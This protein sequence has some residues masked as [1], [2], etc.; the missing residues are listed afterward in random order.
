MNKE[1]NLAVIVI[2][3]ALLIIPIGYIGFSLFYNGTNSDGHWSLEPTQG[4][5]YDGNPHELVVFESTEDTVQY[6]TDGVHYTSAVPTGIDA[7]EYT[8][9]FKVMEGEQV[10]KEDKVKATIAPMPV[11]VKAN[12]CSKVNGEPDPVFTAEVSVK[13]V[14]FNYT[15]SREPGEDFGSYAIT[16]TGTEVQG[17]YRAVYEKGFLF[18]YNEIVVVTPN[19]ASKAFGADD[20]VFTATVSGA[21]GISYTLSREEGEKTGAYKIYATGERVQGDYLV[22]FGTGIFTIMPT[23]SEWKS[24]PTAN[25]YTFD[26]YKKQLV[27]PGT[28]SGGQVLYRLSTGY[29]SAEIPTASEPGTYTIYCKVAGDE[30]HADSK[31]IVLTA[32]IKEYI[33]NGTEKKQPQKLNG[34]YMIYLPSE[35]AWVSAQNKS[36]NGFSGVTFQ[37]M[38]DMDLRHKSWTP[39]GSVDSSTTCPFKGIMNGNGYTISNLFVDSEEYSG[40]FGYVSGGML[41]GIN[42]A[43]IEVHGTEYVGGIAGYLDSQADGLG[44][45]HVDVTGNRYVGV[46]AG[47]QNAG[48]YDCVISYATLTCSRINMSTP[49]ILTYLGNDAGGISGMCNADIKDC[50]VRHLTIN[51]YRNV[52]G[53]VGNV[54]DNKRSIVISGCDVSFSTIMVNVNE[55]S[56]DI[57]VGMISDTTVLSYNTF[58]NAGVVFV[59]SEDGDDTD[60]ARNLFTGEYEYIISKTDGSVEYKRIGESAVTEQNMHQIVLD[61][62]TI[63]RQSE[64][65]DHPAI[66]VQTGAYIVLIIKNSVTLTGGIDSDAIR[67]YAGG[68]VTVTGGGSLTVVGNN[69]HEYY[70]KDG[71]KSKGD[72]DTYNGTG[73]CGIGYSKGATGT[74]RIADLGSISAYGWGN[75]GYGIGGDGATVIINKSTV[76]IARGGFDETEFLVSSYGNEE[77]EGGPAIGGAT[78]I[79]NNGTHIVEAY[80]G[81]KSAGIGTRFWQGGI[82]EISDSTI[83]KVVGGNGSAGIGSSHPNRTADNPTSVTIVI[84]NSEITAIGGYYG[85]GIGSGYDRKTGNAGWIDLTIYITSFSKITAEG[86]KFAADIGTG[87]HSGIL[88]GAI[89]SNVKYN[90]T[91]GTDPKDNSDHTYSYVAQAIGYGVVD[92]SRE[93]ASLM[94]G[95]TPVITSFTIAGEPLTNPF[96][97][98]RLAE[99]KEKYPTS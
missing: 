5:V 54:Q 43:F 90:V 96:D 74:I 91:E 13:G 80:G 88:K 68:E 81:S 53:L 50:A 1:R 52:G 92:Y 4:L 47:Y 70:D 19:D 98:D 84:E 10:L 40:L 30:S 8:I 60:A 15:L 55:K 63:G 25:S 36:N 28:G 73:G 17:N 61:G 72:K 23:A 67:V 39:I 62:V 3:V 57:F 22:E 87:Y 45:Y 9:Y 35:L 56:G 86:G 83:D 64:P 46:I 94:S 77:A 65:T 27:N 12:D 33:W 42:V 44:A 93:A 78:I 37:I 41:S 66:T 11:I 18:I 32:E 29:Y 51:A 59:T 16:P 31:E 49:Y 76:T 71:Y 85:A 97:P 69:G 24:E 82:I 2:I 7:Q 38:H 99:V 89:E 6:S 75:H 95:T 58:A 48:I 21:T 26:G 79:I 34:E 14:E 20:P